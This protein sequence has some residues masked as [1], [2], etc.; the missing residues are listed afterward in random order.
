MGNGGRVTDDDARRADL[1]RSMLPSA[2]EM[3]VPLL[4]N[5]VLPLVAYA[6]LRPAIGSDVVALA[7]MLVFPV[8]DVTVA[9]LRRRPPEPVAVIA[10]TTVVLTLAGTVLLSGGPL[11]LKIRPSTVTMVFGIGCLASLLLPRPAMFH[12]GRSFAV[13]RDPGCGDAVDALS[14]DPQVRATLRWLTLVWGLALLAQGAI[15]IVLALSTTTGLFLVGSFVVD[16][17]GLA[18]L[19]VFTATSVRR[20]APPPR[21]PR[22]GLAT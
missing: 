13:A 5:G 17:A 14:H 10:F 19:L 4:V 21:S 7:A 3:R 20:L 16:W 12:V 9:L 18:A 15:N 8:L 1:L 22:A 11:L 2:A 6:A